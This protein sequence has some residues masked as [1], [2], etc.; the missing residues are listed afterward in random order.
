[1]LCQPT[2]LYLRRLM[3]RY[4]HTLTI[5]FALS[6]FLLL[7]FAYASRNNAKAYGHLAITASHSWTLQDGA[8]SLPEAKAGTAYEFQFNTEGGLAPLKWSVASGSLPPGLRL[9]EQGKLSGN[10]AQAKAEAY[11]FVV[12]VSDSARPPQRFPLPCLLF[13]RAATL[14][15]LTAQAASG[16]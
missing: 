5:A 1:M 10:P 13:V 8:F 16:F 9:D 15:I 11:A 4:S 12:E 7:N 2:H 3:R 14:R 6:F